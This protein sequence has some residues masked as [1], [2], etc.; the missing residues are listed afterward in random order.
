MPSDTDAQK[1]EEQL[2]QLHL[3]WVQANRTGDTAW[4]RANMR[5]GPDQIRLFNTNGSEYLGVEHW[6]DLWDIYRDRIKGDR[7]K[8]EPPLF[9]SVDP[10]IEVCGTVA[11]RVRSRFTKS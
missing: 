1:D 8:K 3:D 2:L 11:A 4:C 10:K 5:S 9:E 7:V 6:C